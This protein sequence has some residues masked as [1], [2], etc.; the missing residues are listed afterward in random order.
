MADESEVALFEHAFAGLL[1]PT[2]VYH[3]LRQTETGE[4]RIQST[5]HTTHTHTPHASEATN[6]RRHLTKESHDK[7]KASTSTKVLTSCASVEQ[8][9][10]TNSGD[11][12][13][14][15]SNTL[16]EPLCLECSVTAF[17]KSVRG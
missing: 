17:V 5:L 7:V 11:F 2:L 16:H 14:R 9:S 6:N 8:L 3:H 12:L 1:H 10:V 4:Q 13:G 15:Y